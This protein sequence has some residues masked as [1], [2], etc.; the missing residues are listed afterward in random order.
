MQVTVVPFYQAFC[1]DTYRE[2]QCVVIDVL[3]A[4]SVIVTAL[5]HSIR[6]V[7]VTHT[8]ADAIFLSNKLGRK[9]C[10]LSGERQ[11]HKIDG[12]DFGNSPI[13]YTND[14]YSNRDLVL[15]TTNGTKALSHARKLKKVWIASFLN[16]EAIV[17]QLYKNGEDLVL[18]CSGNRGHFSLEDALCAKLIIDRLSDVIRLN[19]DSSSDQFLKKLPLGDKGIKSALSKS[20]SCNKLLNLGAKKDFEFCIQKNI[21]S[22]APRC[23]YGKVCF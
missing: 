11:C 22:I 6:K 7:Y 19:L 23:F 18:L 9:N 20:I 4:T 5:A 15:T 17:A 16:V 12:F 1:P 2:R 3:R 14:Q 21:Y 13:P 8:V 10:I